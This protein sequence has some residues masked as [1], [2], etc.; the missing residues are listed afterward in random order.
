MNSVFPLSP[1]HLLENN[2]VGHENM[3]SSIYRL[4]HDNLCLTFPT[5]QLSFL[6]VYKAIR[7][8]KYQSQS[9]SLPACLSLAT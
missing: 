7:P 3:P 8:P 5:V 9:V 6:R 2:N 4:Q 1:V